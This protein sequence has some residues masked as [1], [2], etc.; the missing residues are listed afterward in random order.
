MAPT[1]RICHAEEKSRQVDVESSTA[2][3]DGQTNVS[4]GERQ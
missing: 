1:E 3:K 4:C 2:I